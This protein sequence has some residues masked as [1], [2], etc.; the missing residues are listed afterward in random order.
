MT[1]TATWRRTG[2]LIIAS[3]ILAIAALALTPPASAAPGNLAGSWTSVDVDGSHQTLRIRGS[4]KPVYAMFFRDDFTSGACGGPPAKV[5][6]HALVRGQELLMRG[7][8]V[9]H[10]GG[11]PLPGERISMGLH[12]D[13]GNDTLTDGAG[14]VWERAA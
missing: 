14:V 5:V 4:G 12:Y 9:C 13:A 6:G 8:L 3:G 2:P 11:N 7:T 1:A 10:R